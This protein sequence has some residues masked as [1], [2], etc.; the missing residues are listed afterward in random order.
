MRAS[1]FIHNFYL[2]K[3][4]TLRDYMYF[5][6]LVRGYHEKNRFKDLRVAIECAIDQCIAE[7]GLKQ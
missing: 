1:F 4:P 3:C 6:D 7:N 2:S 5:V